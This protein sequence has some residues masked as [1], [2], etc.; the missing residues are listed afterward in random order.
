MNTTIFN[1]PGTIESARALARALGPLVC[2]SNNPNDP[3]ALLAAQANHDIRVA[4]WCECK[5]PSC[6]Q[7]YYRDQATGAHGWMCGTCRKTTQTG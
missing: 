1:L 6:D 5:Y 7:V 2:A 4:G 3:T